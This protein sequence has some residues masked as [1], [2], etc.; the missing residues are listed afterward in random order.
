MRLRSQFNIL[1]GIAVVVGSSALLMLAWSAWD[2]RQVTQQQDR[3]V[4][5]AR[6]VTGMLVLTQ[7][8]LLHAEPRAQ[9]QWLARYRQ[10]SQLY[11]EVREPE[12]WGEPMHLPID[13][14]MALPELFAELTHLP[15]KDQESP[16]QSR[17]RELLVD[18]LLTE[19]EAI[20]ERAYERERALTQSRNATE[21]RLMILAVL[22]PALLVLVFGISGRLLAGR[23]LAPLAQLRRSM[24]ALAAGQPSVWAGSTA[25]DELGEFSRRFDN[26]IEQLEQRNT[27]LRSSEAM[28]RLVTDNLPAMIGYWDRHLRNQFANADYRRWFGKS[29][30]EILGHRID[31]LLVPDLYQM[32]RP[33]IEGAL[34]G[35]RQ[36]FA[37]SIPGPDGLLRHSQATYIPDTRTGQVEGFFVLVTDVTERVNSEKALAAAL[38]EKNTLLKEV[39]HRVKNNLQV[40]QSLLNLQGRKVLDDGA[41]TALREMAQRVRSMSLVHELLYRSANL[42]AVP[43]GGYVRA[44]AHQLSMSAEHPTGEVRVTVEAPDIEIG[45]DTAIPLGLLLTELISNGFK[46]GFPAGRLG[47][48]MVSFSADSQGMRISVSDD[49]VGLPTGFDPSRSTSMGLQLACSLAR[50]LGGELRFQ[51][52]P[53][54]TAWLVVPNLGEARHER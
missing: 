37:R 13:E 12:Q 45:M 36:E 26:L 25:Q 29:P 21:S 35:Q 16:L 40:V 6:E 41:R 27:A 51:S 52:G 30:E 15:N 20:A 49:G 53:G 42:T 44:L 24:D 43:L 32:N 33:F 1:I 19:A 38:E 3:A 5:I 50:Q 11:A 31:E 18:Q 4:K 23:V 54:T 47:H 14:I 22:L 39:Y 46:H 34:A 8:Y 7:D 48:I 28:L 2:V 10:L 17:R 9:Q